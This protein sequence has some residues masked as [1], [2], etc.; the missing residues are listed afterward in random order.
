[1]ANEIITTKDVESKVFTIRNQ[2]VILDC[3]VATLY[4]VETKRVNEAVRNNREKFPEGFIIELDNEESA[5]LRSKISSLKH[6]K[7]SGSNISKYNYKAFTEKGLYMLATILKSK[8]AVKTTIA[9]IETFTMMRN[10]AQNI[11]ELQDVSLDDNKRKNILLQSG[12]IMAE[13]IGANLTT[14]SVE[15][16]IEIN[17]AAIRIKHKII[18]KDK[19]DDKK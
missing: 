2:R 3:D 16:E 14:K 12:K 10:L 13:A 6:S 17:L 7:G 4:G 15:T 11:E 5:V 9:I 19:E 1:M 18:R 8:Q